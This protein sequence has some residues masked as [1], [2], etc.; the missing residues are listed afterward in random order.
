MRSYFHKSA[1]GDNREK[2]RRLVKEIADI[3]FIITDSELEALLLENT[4]IKKHQPR[5]NI[6]LKD[7]KRYPYIKVHW[8]ND[9][10]EKRPLRGDYKM[11]AGDIMARILRH[12]RLIKRWI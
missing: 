10:P 8:Q 5:Y 2:T 3:E 12:G 7:D 9:Y 4:L 11:T 6:K 1:G